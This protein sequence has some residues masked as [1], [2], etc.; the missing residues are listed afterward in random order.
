M[1]QQAEKDREGTISYLIRGS[2]RRAF[3]PWSLP[4][5][6]FLMML[7]PNYRKQKAGQGIGYDLLAGEDDRT[8][9]EN[10]E[11]ILKCPETESRI[12]HVLL[13]SRQTRCAPLRRGASNGFSADLK[14]G[15]AGCIGLRLM[16]VFC[17]WG[18]GF[19]SSLQAKDDSETWPSWVHGSIPHKSRE[20]ALV[21][22]L[23]CLWKANDLKL[24]AVASFFDAANAF[25]CTEHTELKARSQ[26]MHSKEDLPFLIQLHWC[27]SVVILCRDGEVVMYPGNGVLMGHALAPPTF[28]RDY[29]ESVKDWQLVMAKHDKHYKNLFTTCPVTDLLNDLS[30]ATC[31]DDIGKAM[32]HENNDHQNLFQLAK[33]H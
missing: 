11:K 26:R 28:T 22:I 12:Q 20:G 10:K 23:S 8:P 15:K 16:H 27:S 5:E 29:S 9:E 25:G 18:M 6:I 31:V 13:H 33:N 17:A 30:L 19:Y 4:A 3:A 24:S 14:N 1:M 32:I 2:K 7:L 21:T